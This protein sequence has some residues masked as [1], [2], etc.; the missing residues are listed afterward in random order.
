[1]TTYFEER[2]RVSASEREQTLLARLPSAL[3]RARERAPA[4]AVQLQGLDL[5]A[6]GARSDLAQI[7]VIRKS[8]LLQA[9]LAMRQG[10]AGQE[11]PAVGR[12]FGGFSAIGWGEAAR[13]FASP[14][15]IYE[16]ESKRPDYWG[17]ARALYAAGFRPGELVHNC[18]SYHFTPAGSM[19][20][21]AAHALGCTVFPGGVGQTEQQVQAIADLAPAGYTGTPSFLKIIVEKAIEMGMKLPSIKRALFSGEAFPPSLCAWF[22]EHGIAGYQAY[23]SADLGMIAY[24]TAARDGLV[25]N[26]DIIL[27]IVRPGGNEPLPEG[28]VGEVVVTTL[29]PDYPLVRFGT[30]DLSAI[31]PGVSPCGRTNLRIKGWMGRA[32]QTTKVRGM[33]VHPGQIAQVIKRHP[34]VNKARLIVNGKVGSDIM[35]LMVELRAPTPELLGKLADSV[36][37]LTKLRAE[38]QPVEPGSLPN[39]GKVIDDIRSYE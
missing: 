32:D 35:V 37:E 4:I 21:T 14:G 34:E 11:L 7:P 27:E 25:V 1:M 22:S 33:F 8:E 12:V 9:Q 24:E 5:D 31:L 23:G 30:G 19:M 38:V 17:F 26:E 18:F 10:G 13:V 2:E 28:E 39:D 15:P 6:F 16:P 3:K 29:N 36:R 20:E